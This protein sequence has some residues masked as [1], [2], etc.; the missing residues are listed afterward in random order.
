M[1]KI[2][3]YL[4]GQDRP[5]AVLP[6]TDRWADRRVTTFVSGHTHDARVIPIA[7]GRW[8]VNSGTWRKTI[9]RAPDGVGDAWGAV[10]QLA[11]AV[12]YDGDEIARATDRA[13]RTPS[14]D[15]WQGASQRF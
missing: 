12:L 8:Y 14:F 6:K 13:T 10:K 11:Y 3:A 2:N 4:A 15:L 1:D 9:L 7:P 5:W